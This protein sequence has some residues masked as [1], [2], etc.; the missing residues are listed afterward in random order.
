[1]RSKTKKLI[2]TILLALLYGGIT[3]A[4]DSL[5]VIEIN[6]F[7]NQNIQKFKDS[8]PIT[9]SILDSSGFQMRIRKG[10]GI[11]KVY[12]Q[13]SADQFEEVKASQSKKDTAIYPIKSLDLSQGN[14]R[15][16][17]CTKGDTCVTVSLIVNEESYVELDEKPTV[18]VERCT[19]VAANWFDT[20]VNCKRSIADNDFGELFRTY[21]KKKVVYIYD[22][23]PDPALR[24]F[25]K[26]RK[27][28]RS[29][30]TTYV[31]FNQEKVRPSQ[32][33]QFKVHHINRFMYDIKV[34]NTLM[35]Y[36]SQPSA[37]FSQFFLGDSNLLGKLMG[38]FAAGLSDKAGLMDDFQSRYEGLFTDVQCFLQKYNDLQ[39]RWL[40]AYNPCTVFDCCEGVQYQNIA[41]D[42]LEMRAKMA[43][44]QSVMNE[45]TTALKANVEKLKA[46]EKLF[47]D[48]EAVQ[49]EIDEIEKKPEASRS[50]EEKKKLG[51]L[52]KKNAEIS[53]C[54]EFKRTTEQLQAEVKSFNY[55]A[56]LFSKM[57][58]ELELK[59]LTGFLN[60][61]VKHNQTHVTSHLPL[62]GNRL[63][64]SMVIRSKD[65]VT[66]Y[67]STPSY[68]DSVN[69]EIPVILKPFVSFSAGSFVTLGS[70]LDNK[71]YDWQA[72]PNGSNTVTDT[73]RYMLV[74]SG[75][76][77]PVMGF[78][79]LGNI[80]WKLSRSFGFG[81]ST[82]VGLTIEEKPRPSY[83]L[84]GSL[85]FGDLRQ[86]A[87][88]GGLAIMQANRLKNNLEYVSGE[89][90][91]YK[92]D[93]EPIEYYKET[94]R[95]AFIS[96]TYTP[97]NPIRN[98]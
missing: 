91:I 30:E 7:K 74:E 26:V 23:N 75:Y 22:F 92:T 25:Y 49:K 18:P 31:N 88:T 64:I 21:N 43:K 95:G 35:G 87:L 52:K 12:V 15:I 81:L 33:L 86:F 76:S 89:R 37:L 17:L 11:S 14:P 84:G 41:N 65:S 68:F 38:A 67:L 55:I 16:R 69:I 47:A 93:Q 19:A 71:T 50:E 97:F 53:K 28:G 90:V 61:M 60:N 20:T 9:K 79:A 98:K 56:E 42:L 27:K 77:A 29:L 82:G 5:P 94:R 44:L 24:G 63:D 85:F 2:T 62:H 70:H 6:D 96:L 39:A 72:I 40:Q 13:K 73:S 66:K 46:C 36:D 45:K 4:Q 34:N 32:D 1:M 83:L 80:E 59:Q 10:S 58:Q 48:S 3:H 8:T 57:P 51:E 54:T 78:A